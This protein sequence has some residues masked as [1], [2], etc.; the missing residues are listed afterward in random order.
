MGM[1]FMSDDTLDLLQKLNMGFNAEGLARMRAADANPGANPP[2][3]KNKI[4]R[5]LNGNDAGSKAEL[6]LI[7]NS[8]GIWPTRTTRGKGR[9]MSF[10]KGLKSYPAHNTIRDHLATWIYAAAP[11]VDQIVFDTAEHTAATT[12]ANCWGDGAR[13]G[14][15]LLLTKIFD[16]T[17]LGEEDE[18]IG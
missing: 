11:I 3:R 7:S 17:E 12:V 18:G 15:V 13:N 9:W 6:A 16:S 8:L 2:H 5:W 10:L 14:H 4:K 1:L